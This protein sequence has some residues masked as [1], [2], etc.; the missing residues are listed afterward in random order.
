[1]KTLSDKAVE[2]Y[3][4]YNAQILNTVIRSF[5]IEYS[6]SGTVTPLQLQ[7]IIE[8][9]SH[10][11]LSLTSILEFDIKEAL[12][13]EISF[14]VGSFLHRQIPTDILIS[15]MKFWKTAIMANLPANLS[16][17]IVNFITSNHNYDPHSLFKNETPPLEITPFIRALMDND[18]IIAFSLVKDYFSNNDIECTIEQLF[19]QS[20][21]DIGTLWWQNKI[22]VADEHIASLNLLIVAHQIFSTLT[23]ENKL[24]K[25]I[26]ITSVPG[27]LH[28]IGMNLLS[29]Y[30]EYKGWTVIFM[31]SSMPK[32]DI[33]S[34]LTAFKPDALIISVSMLAFLIQFK[35]LMQDVRNEFPKML[36]IGGGSKSYQPILKQFCNHVPENYSDCHKVL[37]K[38]L[39]HA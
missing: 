32:Q 18:R 17:E 23:S 28:S 30:L 29:R 8:A 31:G 21:R 10:F 2:S 37:L 9:Q 26:C 24:E 36:T 6:H 11:A 25:K 20:L 5:Q 4:Q 14:I 12:S 3:H 27:D 35:S 15:M 22:S 7:F 38:E 33:L 39:I 19:L 1:M 16:A 34:A 13:E